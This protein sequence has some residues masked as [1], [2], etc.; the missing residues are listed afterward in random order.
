MRIALKF[1][2]IAAA[3]G[4][5]AG[6]DNEVI[7][8][9]E[10]R[11]VE[12]TVAFHI[13]VQD[14][15]IED[16]PP[17]KVLRGHTINTKNPTQD[18]HTFGSWHTSE[19]LTDDTRFEKDRPITR[20]MELW[21][22]WIPKERTDWSAYPTGNPTTS[23]TISFLDMIHLIEDNITLGTDYGVT[24]GTLTRESETDYTLEI[25]VEREMEITL[26]LVEVSDLKEDSK[27]VTL[28]WTPPPPGTFRV[29]FHANNANV[30]LSGAPSQQTITEGGTPA[31]P[32]A[33]G[34]AIS[35]VTFVRWTTDQAGHNAFDS[36]QPI[37]A[38]TDVYAQWRPNRFTV[39][40]NRGDSDANGALFKDYDVTW[41]Q[42]LWVDSP[43]RAGH[44][45]NGW[46]VSIYEMQHEDEALVQVYPQWHV[47]INYLTIQFDL[48][49][50]GN[51]P[52]QYV[53][54]GGSLSPPSPTASDALFNGWVTTKGGSTRFNFNNIRSSATV[55][56]WWQK[57]AGSG[58][59]TAANGNAT[60]AGGNTI[61][62]VAYGMGM[63]I[64]VGN[65]GYVA[66]SRDGRNF[67]LANNNGIWSGDRRDNLRSVTFDGRE[68]I[69]GGNKG[70]VYRCDSNGV[71]GYVAHEDRAG[72]AGNQVYGM[73]SNHG[74]GSNTRHV[75]GLGHGGRVSHII[76]GN[77]THTY[78][79]DYP[80]ISRGS[81][82][83]VAYGNGHFILV[84]ENG[85]VA[86]YTLRDNQRGL[87]KKATTVHGGA[88]LLG[89]AF[90]PD[91][92]RWILV[93]DGGRM[94][95]STN[96]GDSWTEIPR[97]DTGFNG[98][99]IR[100]ISYGNGTWLAVGW[101]GKMSYSI[102]GRTFTAIPAGS[103]SSGFHSNQEIYSV[104][105]GDNR[106]LASANE[107]KVALSNPRQ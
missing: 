105:H 19:E 107:G 58:T 70:I 35:G 69:I 50:K 94:S 90:D 100:N 34:N 91:S 59:W 48:M 18:G 46:T 71:L 11:T 63:W 64:A 30:E 36:G 33:R 102:N 60:K 29:T 95:F 8:P 45:F 37:H 101:S 62:A 61:N 85:Q 40:L 2:G 32:T 92:N 20:D 76:N 4:L 77:V 6:C 9:P 38:D 67:T 12:Y 55:Y 56:A 57:P 87:W 81:F 99:G 31:L 103:A 16:F 52:T 39:R 44:L 5:L 106:F 82:R 3:I 13:N 15:D 73:A 96:N 7:P 78:T 98:T 75:V 28:S 41:G 47:G 104:A 23:I 54:T 65:N 25:S 51:Q 93:G 49:G 26:T 80:G 86:R 68:F 72:F 84:G 17:E 66:T 24:M 1:L 79:S 89:I 42:T 27:T 74:S 43:T 14:P 83:D 97:G 53:N 88:H 10:D 22:S 21:A